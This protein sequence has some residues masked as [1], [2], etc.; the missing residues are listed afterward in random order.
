MLFGV[1]GVD[2]LA[3]VTAAVV[4]LTCAGGASLGPALQA[5]A[6]DPAVVLRE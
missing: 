2:V 3:C 4:L 1:S 5:S 6:A